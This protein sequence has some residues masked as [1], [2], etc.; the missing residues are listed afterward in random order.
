[1]TKYIQFEL[2]EKG[3]KILVEV[4]EEDIFSSEEG[5]VKAG[6]RSVAKST[7]AIAKDSFSNAIRDAVR[8]NVSGLIDAVT[9]LPNPPDE[10]EI[11]FGLK[12]TGEAGNIAVG[13]ASG[14]VNYAIK[15]SWKKG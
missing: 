6:I 3:K 12:A 11:N 5:I 13:K 14:E 10:I 9:T 1:M 15:L 8:Y 4:E 2:D 7:I